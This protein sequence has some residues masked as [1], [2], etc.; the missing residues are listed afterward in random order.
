LR[1]YERSIAFESALIRCL[2]SDRTQSGVLAVLE[3]YHIKA[4]AELNGVTVPKKEL[5]RAASERGVFAGFDE[6]LLF[7]N[8]SP[9]IAVPDHLFL[10]FSVD[11]NEGLP[12]GL[13]AYMTESRCVLAL[14]DGC[15]L[16]YATW[17]IQF[18]SLIVGE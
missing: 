5:S 18:A 13:E 10:T 7:R 11:F 14:A 6:V 12:E 15:G 9:K 17:D 3:R 16:N 2:D 8:D 1:L 4:R